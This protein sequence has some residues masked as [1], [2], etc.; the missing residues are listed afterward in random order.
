MPEPGNKVALYVSEFVGEM[1]DAR[2]GR[3]GGRGGRGSDRGGRGTGR[4]GHGANIG[5]STRTLRSN[6]PS[7]NI[8]ASSSGTSSNPSS[9]P[10]VDDSTEPTVDREAQVR[11]RELAQEHAELQ[12]RLQAIESERARLNFSN[13]SSSTSS[14]TP[15][16]QN[17]SNLN[18][19]NRENVEAKAQI[20]RE[21]FNANN[22]SQVNVVNRLAAQN[23]LPTFSGNSLE[24]L[25]FKRAFEHSKTLGRYSDTEN[26]SRLFNCLK[27]DARQSVEGLMLTTN[28]AKEIM[29]ALELRYG[30]QSLVLRNL[31]D[32]LR[33]LRLIFLFLILSSRG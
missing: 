27:G 23:E 12:A 7:S 32:A 24:W 25:R 1:S 18:S 20:I 8:S 21:V 5:L 28:S 31:V 30:N 3:G 14:Q 4:G 22:Q 33:N 17:T 26:L 2:G 16:Q 9:N 29:N 15:S 6:A 19:G 10:Q 13:S 11:L